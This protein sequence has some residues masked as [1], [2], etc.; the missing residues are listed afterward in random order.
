MATPPDIIPLA[1]D[2]APDPAPGHP[3]ECPQCGI[4]LRRASVICTACGFHT[5]T[6]APLAAGQPAAP[7]SQCRGC[8]Y[9]MT[10]LPNVRCPEC[11]EVNFGSAAHKSG[12]SV[13]AALT[14]RE[15][16]TPAVMLAI[17]LAVATTAALPGEPLRDVARYL[18][19]YGAAVPIILVL[20][21]AA[22]L[23]WIGIDAPI[24]LTALQLA[25][26]VAV[27]DAAW[28]LGLLVLPVASLAYGLM[29]FAWFWVLSDVLDLDVQDAAL[30]TLIL[31]GARAGV[32][33]ALLMLVP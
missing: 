29:A 11:G 17:G 9:D 8:G 5:G 28:S 13:D 12:P 1:D 30:M 33:I 20:Y 3:R 4:I 2:Q 24:R 14:R 23:L 22:G 19:S 25:A 10:G 18:A 15:Y 6:G 32:A 27:G 16:M 26:A 21:I 7:G 31:T